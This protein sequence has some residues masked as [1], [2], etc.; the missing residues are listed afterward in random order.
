MV[1]INRRRSKRVPPTV[2]TDLDFA[3]D[4][5]VFT[6]EI[7]QAQEVL[8]LLEAEASKVGLYCNATKTEYQ[9]FNISLDHAP[10]V[11]SNG[12]QLKEVT[13]FK[14]LGSWT[15]SSE[16]DFMVR[17]A[18]AWSALHKLKKVWHSNLSLH[19]K[20][21]LFISTVESV[22]LYGSETWTITKAMKKKIDG[23]YTKML[24]IIKGVSW[25]DHMTNL[26]LYGSLPPV[27]TKIQQRRMRLAG[28]CARH[29]EEV[30]SKLVLWQPVD[31]KAKRGR[32]NMSYIDNL[33]EDFGVEQ[34][35][36]LRS[37]M[38]DKDKW[39]D[40]VSS[41]WRPGGRPK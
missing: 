28:H 38:L 20:E 40:R 8:N 9:Q 32:K 24:R 6:E 18:L 29:K 15:E 33:L 25:R 12:T 39:R 10:I 11:S 1:W 4:L 17:K 14:Y 31:G 16:K 5:A 22:L 26:Q 41:L 3:D 23:C 19:I 34:T 30:A 2:I 21:R 13:N 37:C 27:T 35:G 36:E 7:W